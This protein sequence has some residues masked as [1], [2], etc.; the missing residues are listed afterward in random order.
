MELLRGRLSQP[1]RRARSLPAT[2]T[3]GGVM[4]LRFIAGVLARGLV[5]VLAAGCSASSGVADAGASDAA[6]FPLDSG[7][8]CD[9]LLPQLTAGGWDGCFNYCLTGIP[10]DAAF[11]CTLRPFGCHERM[12]YCFSGQVVVSADG[13]MC[14]AGGID[15]S[16]DANTDASVDAG[17]TGDADASI[18]A[19]PRSDAGYVR[20][21]DEAFAAIGGPFRCGAGVSGRPPSIGCDGFTSCTVCSC[22]S[23]PTRRSNTK[24]SPS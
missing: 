6:S 11:R 17:A 18:D 4:R 1:R 10:C 9:A 24:H 14:D 15:A 5:A 20:S 12:A 22:G 2:R 19:G 3:D 7:P 21:C 8:F 13:H 16:V 23:T